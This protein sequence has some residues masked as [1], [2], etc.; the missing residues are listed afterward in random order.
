MRA[1]CQAWAADLRLTPWEETSFK[2]K[3]GVVTNSALPV[4][5]CVTYGKLLNISE[6]W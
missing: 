6:P 2:S 1:L 5:G 3:E 4:T